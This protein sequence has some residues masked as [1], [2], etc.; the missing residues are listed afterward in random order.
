LAKYSNTVEYNIKT[1]LDSKGLTQLKNELRSVE[2]SLQK[3]GDKDLLNT[4]SFSDAR[5]QIQNLR[6]S[7]SKAFDP[8]L[9]ILD[10]SKLNTELKESGVT[11]AS[12]KS[13]FT[14]AGSEG[15][16]A[17]NN[18]VKE[19]CRVD[20]GIQRSNSSLVK[21]FTIFSNTFR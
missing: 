6:E 19:L 12:L 21:M 18:L 3:M 4:K 17:F 9:G 1:S 13:A 7:L 2:L 10:L 20:T 11:A 15:Q 14:Q 5:I 16:V 8:S